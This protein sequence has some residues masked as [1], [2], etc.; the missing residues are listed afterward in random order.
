MHPIGREHSHSRFAAN[1]KRKLTQMTLTKGINMHRIGLSLFAVIALVGCANGPG[2]HPAQSP[3]E[4]TPIEASHR[5]HQMEESL[6]EAQARA[7]RATKEVEMC[8]KAVAELHTV[9]DEL[10]AKAQ[11]YYRAASPVVQQGASDA[12]SA[13]KVWVQKK[14]D[15]QGK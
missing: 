2:A 3:H 10:T 13:G 8:Q 6:N 11:E 5:Q 7:E 14:L 1:Q 9:A 15:E 4:E 12:Y